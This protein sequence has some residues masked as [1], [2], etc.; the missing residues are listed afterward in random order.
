[1]QLQWKSTPCGYLQCNIRQVQNQ[2]QTQEVRLT[3]GMPDIGRVL[4][5]WGQPV[6][7]SKEWRNDTITV[8]GG[9]T[10]WVLY[11]PE[12]G[13]EPRS[14]EVWLPFQLRHTMP[15]SNREGSIRVNCLLRSLDGR[16]LSARKMM[17]RS[18]L[19]ILVEA[20][21][22]AE[23]ELFTP[24]EVPE[25]VELLTKTYPA[26]LP[27]EAGEKL[28][29][30]EETVQLPG[31]AP[32]KLLACDLQPVV[33][34]Q[35][36]LGGRAVFRGHG[37]LHVVYMGEDDQIHSEYTELPFAQ[38]VELDRDYDK[39]VAA[40]VMMT[41]SALDTVLA[42]GLL[43]VKCGLIAQYLIHQRRL[44]DVAEDAY[45]PTRKVVPE[46]QTLELP[47]LLDRRAETLDAAVDMD[48]AQ[49]VDVTFLPDHPTQ[50]REGDLISME[51]PGSFQVLYYDGEQNLQAKTENWFGRLDIPAG[52]GSTILSDVHQPKQPGY[53]LS[54]GQ[55]QL[56]GAVKMELTAGAMQTIPMVTALEIGEE[57]Q[58]DPA[59]PALVLRRME[60]ASLW[61]LAK[62]YG[63]TVDAIRK[64][65]HL[66]DEPI[67]GQMLLIP[68]L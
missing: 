14:V 41:V 18:S 35:A 44:L 45:S 58:P 62:D 53:T 21:E 61:E 9:V 3:D 43:Q 20:L 51:L 23:A 63:S 8:T 52:E 34:E 38:Y 5:A 66:N 2:E 17:V 24:G 7:R 54:G 46:M 48:A 16:T 6:L 37:R 13:S 4:C 65:N 47:V 22:P 64:A 40:S 49:I 39:D 33:T 11:A 68:V 56:D 67:Q 36:A 28:F 59:R 27:A 60:D 10:A 1:M 25:G 26:M 12:D 55:T 57:I 30:L 32:R 42:D 50:Y 31:T 19:G 15:A 29:E